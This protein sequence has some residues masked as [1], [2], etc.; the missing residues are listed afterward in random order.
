M[1][2][3]HY[4]E[5]QK[6][7]G[8]D[9]TS[10][11]EPDSVLDHCVQQREEHGLGDALVLECFVRTA[12]DVP[13]VTENINWQRSRETRKLALCRPSCLGRDPDAE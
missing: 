2:V 11:G 5:W 12:G 8:R 3:L 1:S 9:F 4:L 13:R 6:R 7:Q 10:P